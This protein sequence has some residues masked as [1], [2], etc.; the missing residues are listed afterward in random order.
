VF[1]FFCGD[2]REISIIKERGAKKDIFY[3][4]I[5][6]EASVQLVGVLEL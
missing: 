1:F 6:A 2:Y 4:A 3:K 5:T